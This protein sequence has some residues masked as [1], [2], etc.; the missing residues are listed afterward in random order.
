MEIHQRAVWRGA[1]IATLLVVVEVFG[2]GVARAA[3]AGAGLPRVERAAPRATVDQ[4]IGWARVGIEYGR[5][6]TRGRK[7]FGEMVPFDRVW[8]LG[9]DEATRLVTDAEIALGALVVP[10]G[11]YSLF[12]VPHPR[13]W[14]LVVNKVADQW[15]AWNRNPAQD[16]GRIELD[17]ETL[18]AP[19]DAL[20]LALE[21]T[22]ERSAVLAIAWE[23]MRVTVP[24]SVVG[25]PPVPPAGLP[26]ASGATGPKGASG[27][28]GGARQPATRPAPVPPP[29]A[30]P[31]PPPRPAGKVS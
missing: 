28:T 10:A 17:V 20:T 12:V 24:V 21:P 6:E 26:G 31:P 1:L 4:Q 14:T 5:P 22:G 2:G 7:V 15:G 18:E 23:L 9:S 11:S 13:T 29:A 3:P 16:L 25:E 27:S 30:T 19:V 8:R